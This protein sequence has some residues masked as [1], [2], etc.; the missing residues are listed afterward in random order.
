MPHA[1]SWPLNVFLF[2]D[3]SEIRIEC[4][5]ALKG[6]CCRVVYALYIFEVD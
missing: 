4:T 3:E 6:A 1:H 5:K 2:L